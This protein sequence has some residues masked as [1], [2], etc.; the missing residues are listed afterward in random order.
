M[1]LH[2]PLPRICSGISEDITLPL[3]GLISLLEHSAETVGPQDSQSL[4]DVNMH[5]FHPTGRSQLAFCH[6]GDPPKRY[7]VGIHQQSS[8]PVTIKPLTWTLGTSPDGPAASDVLRTLTL[9]HQDG[10]FTHLAFQ[11]KVTFLSKKVQVLQ[12]KNNQVESLG[13]NPVQMSVLR[14][15]AHI[16][17]FHTSPVPGLED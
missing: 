17:L 16:F 8:F 13:R 5:P 3:E 11:D 2:N 15:K 7:L 14:S 1:K 9:H 10:E 12:E 4:S 6:R